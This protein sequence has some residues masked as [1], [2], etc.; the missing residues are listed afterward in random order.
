MQQRLVHRPSA[1]RPDQLLTLRLPVPC[2]YILWQPREV[3]LSPKL[4]TS[5]PSVIPYIEWVFLGLG[6]IGL[7]INAIW[8]ILNFSGWHNQNYWFYLATNLSERLNEFT[9]P[10]DPFKKRVPRP[11]G[12]I[13]WLAQTIPVGLSLAN[14]AAGSLGLTKLGFSW[15]NCLMAGGVF[16][17]AIA[18]CI[19]RIEYIALAPPSSGTKER[20]L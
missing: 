1:E 19:F 17:I 7:F 20:P 13:Y 12:L 9:L 4:W 18:L 15:L 3:S 6:L 10:T 11:F 14:T 2:P 8:H 16:W 5:P